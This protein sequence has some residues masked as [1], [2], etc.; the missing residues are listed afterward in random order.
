MTALQVEA[1]KGKNGAVRRDPVISEHPI[2]RTHPVTGEKA[3][4]VNP[5]CKWDIT[6]AHVPLI[7]S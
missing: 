3:L 6:L 5:Q 7:L 4:Y 1:S 2:V